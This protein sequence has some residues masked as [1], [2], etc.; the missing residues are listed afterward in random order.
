MPSRM[1]KCLSY[2]EGIDRSKGGFEGLQAAQECIKTNETKDAFARDYVDLAKVWEAVS[3][4]PILN[5]YQQDFKWLSQVYLS[6][7]PSSDDA[8]GCYG[9][10][11]GTDNSTD[12]RAC[13]F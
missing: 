1:D 3:P 11:L 13:S 7:K 4:D 5:L 9:T 10:P 6:V 8:E 12:Q 2:F